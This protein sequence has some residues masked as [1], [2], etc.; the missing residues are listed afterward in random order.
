MWQRF[1]E[2]ARRAVYHSQE[3]AQAFGEGYVSTEHLLLGLL[4]DT[5]TCA[6]QAIERLGVSVTSVHTE[7]VKQ[8]PRGDA[9]PSQDMTFTPRAKRVIDLAYDEARNL[10]NNFIGTEHLFLGLVREGEGLAGRVLAKLGIDLERARREVL[11]IQAGQPSPTAPSAPAA[12]SPSTW[13]LGTP[14]L[15]AAL[16]AVRHRRYGPD[17]LALLI[18][19]DRSSGVEEALIKLDLSPAPLVAEIESAMLAMNIDQPAPI[20]ELSEIVQET[21]DL[22]TIFRHIALRSGTATAAAFERL[23]IAPLRLAEALS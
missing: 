11:A 17:L 20:G 8:L 1:H 3:E 9:R 4:R 19:G 14:V 10:G 7:V 18:L 22:K 13:R 21:G 6:I 12:A 5:G 16:L 2:S 23:G 15:A